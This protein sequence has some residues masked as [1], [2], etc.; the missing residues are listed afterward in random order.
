MQKDR[1]RC[2]NAPAFLHFC[3]FAFRFGAPWPYNYNY[4]NLDIILYYIAI[5][6]KKTFAKLQKCKIAKTLVTIQPI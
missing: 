4:N 1:K 2:N 3:I 6:A 5:F